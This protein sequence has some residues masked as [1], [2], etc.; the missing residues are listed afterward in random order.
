MSQVSDLKQTD[1]QIVVE[2]PVPHYPT[3]QPADAVPW[4][5]PEHTWMNSAPTRS[6]PSNDRH[7]MPP[8]SSKLD[9]LGQLISQK[10]ELENLANSAGCAASPTSASVLPKGGGLS[11]SAEQSLTTEPLPAPE[12]LPTVFDHSRAAEQL[13]VALEALVTAEQ[14]PGAEQLRGVEQLPHSGQLPATDQLP[15]IVQFLVV[16]QLTAADG[17]S[18]PKELP[19][20]ERLPA[21]GLPA[22]DSKTSILADGALKSESNVAPSRCLP[23]VGLSTV[24]GDVALDWCDLWPFYQGELEPHCRELSSFAT[25]HCSELTGSGWRI[26]R[27][28]VKV[29]V[30][31]VARQMPTRAGRQW[32]GAILWWHHIHTMP[33]QQAHLYILRNIICT[34][35]E[36][37][38]SLV[39]RDST[40]IRGDQDSGEKPNS[41]SGRHGRPG[42]DP[43]RESTF[44]VVIRAL[45]SRPGGPGYQD[46]ES[47]VKAATDDG[48]L[49]LLAGLSSMVY[50]RVLTDFFFSGRA[51]RNLLPRFWRSP[52]DWEV[53][54]QELATKASLLLAHFD[55]ELEDEFKRHGGSLLWAAKYTTAIGANLMEGNMWKGWLIV[56]M[57]MSKA[58]GVKP[59]YLC[60][61]SISHALA[62]IHH[63]ICHKTQPALPDQKL[64]NCTRHDECLATILNDDTAKSLLEKKKLELSPVLWNPLIVKHLR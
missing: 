15:A 44:Q 21:A 53:N 43:D 55:P 12:Q 25:A 4:C 50:G 13:P 24:A 59:F 33:Y 51:V 10:D 30:D 18:A 61:A 28:D 54:A 2:I 20:T 34:C 62:E 45:V 41:N 27:G 63:Q 23:G 46:V 39:S 52:N 64:S 6:C 7:T 8:C 35:A 58:W 49:P 19:N 48:R 26:L 56:I 16:E 36:T 14:L 1:A 29:I 60:L 32:L 37:A 5:P 9:T 47:L 31:D 22:A 42:R 38:A 11:D 17:L 3:K 57:L 40:R